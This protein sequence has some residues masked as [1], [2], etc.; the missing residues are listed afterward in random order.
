MTH[1]IESSLLFI[2]LGAT[3]DLTKRKLIPALFKIAKKNMN[4]NMKILCVA[5]TD[6]SEESFQNAIIEFSK[7]KIADAILLDEFILWI[8]NNVTYFSNPQ[9]SP[10]DFIMM[11]HKIDN[12]EKQHNLSGNRIFYLSMPPSG[13]TRSVT[14][15]G[16]YESLRENGWIR[17]VIEK[18]FGHNFESAQSLNMLLHEYFEESE[19]YRIDHYLGKETVQ[20]LL[21]FRFANPIFESLWN[22][23]KIEYVEITMAEELGVENRAGYYDKAGAVRDMAQNHLTQLLTL[24]AMEIPASFKDEYIR[25]EKIKVLRTINFIEPE[26]IVFGQYSEG[27][28]NENKAPAYINEPGIPEFSK[29]ETFVAAKLEIS[30]WRWE[31]TPFYIRTGKRLP[32]R[33]TQ[34]IINFKRPPVSFFQ[35]FNTCYIHRNSL[36]VIIQPDEGF[37][38]SFEIKKPGQDIEVQ[39]HN[40]KFRYGDVFSEIP[41]A[42]ETLLLDIIHGDQT[43]F[44]HSDETELS[45]KLWESAIK[46]KIN[47]NY[48]PAGT[49]GPEASDLL[50]KKDGRKWKNQ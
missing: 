20:N 10:E 26:N 36:T 34:V 43:L 3:G 35:P 44:V 12:Y 5:R 39:T 4:K 49:W 46:N 48:Y 8:K 25:Q 37:D 41:E 31:G 1:E 50:I 21:V 14:G 45:Y 17:F 22:R 27:K 42:Y 6:I 23:D 11:M 47:L 13:F 28:I 7:D 18:P 16:S 40:M 9:T 24:L 32:K 29:T 15:I 19:I 30:N 33:I 38:L 2:I